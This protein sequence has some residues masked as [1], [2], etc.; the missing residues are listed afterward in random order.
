MNALWPRFLGSIYRK[1]PLVSFMVTV[2]G[3][4]AAI[5]GLSQ[6][7]SL[8]GLGVSTVG[9][10]IVFY[11]QQC[12]RPRLLNSVSRSSVYVLPAQ[13]SRPRLPTIQTPKQNS[14]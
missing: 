10:A 2:G 3:V 12:R 14:F 9:M 5:G 6:H 4:D 7:W 11:W 8:L 13:S 1:Q